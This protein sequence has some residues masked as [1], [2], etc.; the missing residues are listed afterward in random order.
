[1]FECFTLLDIE[2]GFFIDETALRKSYMRKSRHFHPDFFVDKNDEEKAEALGISTAITNAYQILSDFDRR[3][4]YILGER[5]LLGGDDKLP[6]DFLV[7]MME[8]NEELDLLAETKDKESLK[9]FTK[10]IEQRM[11]AMREELAQNLVKTSP[12][13]GNLAQAKL[14]FLKMKYLLRIQEK[15]STFASAFETEM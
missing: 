13:D 14:F 3:L 8:A 1:M 2:P 7:E 12:I 4:R 11:A 15:V 9:G 5:A 10:S 6:M